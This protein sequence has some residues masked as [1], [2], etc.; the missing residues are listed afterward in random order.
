MRVLETT[1]WS[2]FVL[3]A[4]STTQTD[5]VARGGEHHHGG[6]GGWT[7]GGRPEDDAS[8]SHSVLSH[9]E[10]ADHSSDFTASRDF[11]ATS[12]FDASSGVKEKGPEAISVDDFGAG[13][14]LGPVH[15]D[16]VGAAHPESKTQKKQEPKAQ[17][18]CGDNP[19]SC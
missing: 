12:G 8:K 18:S 16:D 4:L 15:E 10:E 9:P 1:V 14:T 6:R 11:T 7:E 3:A 2:L 17:T 5:A 13:V 19:K